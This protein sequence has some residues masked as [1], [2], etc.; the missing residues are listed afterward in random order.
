M[1]K[2]WR[3]ADADATPPQ[4]SSPTHAAWKNGSI[5]GGGG[6]KRSSAHAAPLWVRDPVCVSNEPSPMTLIGDADWQNTSPITKSLE[7]RLP[8]SVS[9][10][11]FRKQKERKRRTNTHFIHYKQ[12]QMHMLYPLY[13]YIHHTSHV[14]MRWNIFWVCNG[15]RSAFALSSWGEISNYVLMGTWNGML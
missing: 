10:D 12:L 9:Y 6:W 8:T 13:I 3:S 2:P 11:E 4:Q 5:R 1:S 14:L 7:T 15:R